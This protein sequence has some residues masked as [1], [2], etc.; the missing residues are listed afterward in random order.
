VLD[1]PSDKLLAESPRA[2]LFFHADNNIKVTANSRGR[3][4][5]PGTRALHDTLHCKDVLFLDFI[6][7]CLD[8]DPKTRMTPEEAF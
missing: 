8:W 4:R 5:H 6:K 1:V 3:V 7:K 2:K